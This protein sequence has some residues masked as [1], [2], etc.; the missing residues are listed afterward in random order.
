[1]SSSSSEVGRGGDMVSVGFT[2]E[3]MMIDDQLLST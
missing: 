1:M 2:E 3:Y